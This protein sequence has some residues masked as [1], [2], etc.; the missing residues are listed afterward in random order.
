MFPT[1]LSGGESSAEGAEAQ[2]D[3]EADTAEEAN[4]EPL[5]GSE[6]SVEVG[7]RSEITVVMV[8][9]A[10]SPGRIRV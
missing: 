2:A 10:P 9:A 1:Y 5:G 6:S 4:E 7:A 8:S 3:T